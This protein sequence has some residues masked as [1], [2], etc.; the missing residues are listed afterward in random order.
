MVSLPIW[1]VVTLAVAY[2][3]VLA[4]ACWQTWRRD[5]ERESREFAEGDRDGILA[6]LTTA[7]KRHESERDEQATATGD[8]DR[9]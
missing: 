6:M 7:S 9:I 2:F 8:G 4:F 5:R 3:V 1:L